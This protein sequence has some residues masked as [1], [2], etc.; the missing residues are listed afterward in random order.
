MRPFRADETLPA[1][2][3]ALG[4]NGY[5]TILEAL[6]TKTPIIG[7]GGIVTK[8]ITEILKTGISGV[9]VS[10]EITQNFDIVKTL[11]QLLSASSTE[12]KRHTF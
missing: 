5:T 10:D 6:Q 7:G 3:T 12:E 1:E 2:N 11:N 4:F 9:A 8:D